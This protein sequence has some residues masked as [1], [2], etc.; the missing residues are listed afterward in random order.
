MPMVDLLLDFVAERQQLAVAGVRSCTIDEK[1]AQKAELPMPVPG[2]AS[3]RIKVVQLTCDFQP[4]SV[5]AD[6]V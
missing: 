1:D 5:E 4:G 3:S 6:G 2:R